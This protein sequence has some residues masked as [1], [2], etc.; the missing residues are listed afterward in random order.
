MKK[1]KAMRA[2]GGMFVVTM[3]TT[4]IVSGTY[5][6]YVT[7]GTVSDTAR[8]AKFGVEIAADGDLF[9]TSYVNATGGNMPSSETSATLTVVSSNDNNVVAPGTKNS[10]G[11]NFG[12]TGQP[13]VAVDITIAAAIKDNK[14]I[15]LKKGTYTDVTVQA[16]TPAKTF[17]LE[18]DYYPIKWTLSK[19]DTPITDYENVTLSKINSYFADM[20]ELKNIKPNTD[21]SDIDALDGYTLSWAWDFDDSGKGTNDKADTVLGDLA[22]GEP[23]VQKFTGST[24]SAPVKNTD[25]STDIEVE[26]TITVTQVD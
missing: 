10:A 4:S 9:G 17:N 15:Y 25:Y 14:D 1:N 6:K 11:L 19:G 20:D 3:L 12:I 21:L 24:G 8:V 5:A 18:S 13:E 7:T 26:F 22:A 23:T 16:S 2:A